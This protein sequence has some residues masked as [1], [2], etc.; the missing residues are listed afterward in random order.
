MT[1]L[2]APRVDLAGKSIVLI[3]PAWHSCGSHTVFCSQVDAYRTLGARVLSLAV[4][5]GLSQNSCKR[6]FWS[7]YFTMTRDLKAHERLCTGPSRTFFR[8][9]QLLGRGLRWITANCAQQ[10][11]D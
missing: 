7:D 4:G 11:A 3:H 9:P 2:S 1:H 6:A 10:W 5:T 8:N